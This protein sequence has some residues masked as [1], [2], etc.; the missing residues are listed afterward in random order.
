MVVSGVV[1][2]YAVEDLGG[3]GYRITDLVGGRD[4]IDVTSGVERIQFSGGPSVT[5]ASLIVP[6]APLAP[7]DKTGGEAQVLPG[8]SDDGF[9]LA[10]DADL[11][12][13]LPAAFDDGLEGV[14]VWPGPMTGGFALTLGE[15]GLLIPGPD[16]FDPAHH[17]DGWNFQ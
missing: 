1:A 17:R 2:D 11:P 4:G 15:D 5:L 12:E 6:V 14:T 16:P 10:K 3:G 7:V 9:L 13:V 8:L